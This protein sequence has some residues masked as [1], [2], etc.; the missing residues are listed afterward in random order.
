MRNVRCMHF[1]YVREL[2][3]SLHTVFEHCEDYTNVRKIIKLFLSLLE[4]LAPIFDFADLSGSR[5]QPARCTGAAA[6][7]EGDDPPWLGP[8]RTPA[9]RHVR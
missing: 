2:N 1:F 4:I 7:R 5:W 6:P 8:C 3:V 9:G